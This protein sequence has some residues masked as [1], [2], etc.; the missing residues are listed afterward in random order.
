MLQIAHRINT[1]DL[2]KKTPCEYG[3]EVDLRD[4]GNRIIIR[5]DAFGDGDDFSKYIEHYNHRFLIA[6]IKCEGIEEKVL[7]ILLKKNIREFFF[8]DLSFPALVKMVKCGE[9]RIAVR[10]SE[11]EPLESVLALA[12]KVSWVWADCFTKFPLCQKSYAMLHNNFKI[13]L[14]SPELQ[15]HPLS[16]IGQFKSMLKPMPI[17]AVCT[18][19]PELWLS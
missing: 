14:V 3:V 7:E 8:L 15:G 16:H 12:G 18:K 6:N 17:D 19:K 13:C 1:I 5:H 11:H 2:L 9:H 4:Q 10:Y